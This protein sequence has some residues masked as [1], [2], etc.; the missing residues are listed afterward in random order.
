MLHKKLLLVVIVISTLATSF[1]SCKDKNNNGYTFLKCHLISL[2]GD[3][4]VKSR[5]S[6]VEHGDTITVYMHEVEGNQ[7]EFDPIVS[8]EKDTTFL[9]EVS[10][11]SRGSKQ[12]YPPHLMHFARAIVM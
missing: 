12:K 1:L 2:N 7:W 10:Y 8:V 9:V 5:T 11:K 6:F 4:K 3:I